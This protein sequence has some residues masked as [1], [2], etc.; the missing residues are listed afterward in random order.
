MPTVSYL[1][2]GGS[3]YELA[4]KKAR[5]DVSTKAEKTAL[6]AVASGS[7]AGVYADLN[8]LQSALDTEKTRIYL[9]L[10][11]GNWCYWNGSTWT[12]GGIYQATEITDKSI[13]ERKTTFFNN[14]SNLFIGDIKNGYAFSDNGETVSEILREGDY[15]TDFIEVEPNTK[16]Y[17][18]TLYAV[19]YT[20]DKTIISFDKFSSDYYNTKYIITPSDCKYIKLSAKSDT[21]VKLVKVGNYFLEENKYKLKDNYVGIIDGSITKTGSINSSKVNFLEQVG[22]LFYKETITVGYNF[23]DEGTIIPHDKSA[24]SDFIK[25]EPTKRYILFALNTC[26][27][28]VN[29][30][31]VKCVTQNSDEVENVANN[32]YVITI[33]EDIKYIRFGMSVN[34]NTDVNAYYVVDLDYPITQSNKIK[35]N[36]IQHSSCLNIEGNLV[37]LDTFTKGIGFGTTGDYLTVYSNDTYMISDFIEVIEN[38]TY[39]LYAFYVAVFDKDYKLIYYKC[40]DGTTDVHNFNVTIPKNGKYLK[41]DT[42]VKN[43]EV[44]MIWCVDNTDT[45]KETIRTLKGN[46]DY[47][48][49]LAKTPSMPRFREATNYNSQ[50]G[51]QCY[52]LGRWEY[53]TID[54]K[55]LVYTGYTGARIFTKLKN[56]T[57]ATFSFY[58]KSSYRLAYRINDGEYNLLSNLSTIYVSGLNPDIENYIEIC[59]TDL[60]ANTWTNNLGVGFD[61][62][63][64]DGTAIAVAPMGRIALVY[65]DSIAQGYG[66]EENKTQA[67]LNFVSKMCK[68]LRCSA[69][70]IGE[71]GIGYVHKANSDFIT[72]KGTEGFE[73]I[74]YNA[75][76]SYIDYM[77]KN[78]KEQSQYPDFIIL[79]LGTNDFPSSTQETNYVTIV[80]N[81]VNRIENKYP[82]VPIF[83]LIPLNGRNSNLLKE[84]YNSCNNV[85]VI[86]CSKYIN[87]EKYDSLHP[88]VTGSDVMG[89]NLAR[90][91]LNYF[92]KSYFLL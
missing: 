9:T 46:L 6:E 53:L 8:A 2:V 30:K 25:V 79:E 48:S 24:I 52:F 38:H 12:K 54:N 21:K 51:N 41:F 37:D 15:V 36:T 91:L 23:D 76:G 87:I 18:Y 17:A 33:P 84:A 64:T 69:V 4:D 86:D 63:V 43:I 70:I 44:D 5:Q 19:F 3:D 7:P 92:G 13:T 77:R 47:S 61:K 89:K 14:V 65:G 31:L 11:D 81:V 45:T 62:V 20:K 40:A 83:G 78:V 49:F 29:L 10:D 58:S 50:F 39:N 16:Y 74:T 66:V 88:N 55:N 1:N 28:D 57:N 90:D 42:L 82:G 35:D 34:K 56:A 68:Y 73:N 60:D 32:I 26:M 67:H 80:K 22:N 85:T 75:T 71:G 59:V 27:Y 72:V